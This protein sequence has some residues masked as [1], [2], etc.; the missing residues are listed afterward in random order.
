MN[1]FRLWSR[2]SETFAI[3]TNFVGAASSWTAKSRCWKRKVDVESGKKNVKR[4]WGSLGHLR[5][6]PTRTYSRW[7]S[8]NCKEKSVQIC[9]WNGDKT[10]D[11]SLQ[12]Q[13]WPKF[14]HCWI[15]QSQK[16]LFVFSCGQEFV[17][18]QIRTI[19][20]VQLVTCRTIFANVSKA[21]SFDSSIL[22]EGTFPKVLR[23]VSEKKLCQQKCVQSSHN[24][25]RGWQQP[26]FE[27]SLYEVC[28]WPEWMFQCTS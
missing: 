5:D 11:K 10:L 14:V 7:T 12:I 19:W 6:S 23:Q 26:S 15:S 17:V 8:L 1:H 24:I 21:D 20:V 9:F 25:V 3:R 4:L 13:D 22:A 28:I 16:Q 18:I 27:W 2:I